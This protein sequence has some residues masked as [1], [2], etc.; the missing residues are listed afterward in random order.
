MPYT[1]FHIRAVDS[2]GDAARLNAFL[3]SRVVLQVERH[4]VSDGENSFWSVCVSTAEGAGPNPAARSHNRRSVD[5]REILSPE[6]F[7]VYA[8]LRTLRNR[9]AE[10]QG[11]PPYAIFTNEQLAAMAQ[12]EAPSRTAIATIEGIGE[13]RLSLY[14]DA[15]L[16]ELENGDAKDPSA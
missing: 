4:F 13:K 10:E 3:D 1:F 14:A 9:L 15:F 11:A 5:Y 8:R 16:A 2:A 7:A 12:L 6:H